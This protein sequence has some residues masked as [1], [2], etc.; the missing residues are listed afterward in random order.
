MGV[1]Q[2]LSMKPRNVHLPHPHPKGGFSDP[3]LG[4]GL[5][6]LSLCLASLVVELSETRLTRD[7]LFDLFSLELAVV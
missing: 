1:G 3:S 5:V 4:V 2:P 7:C 6:V